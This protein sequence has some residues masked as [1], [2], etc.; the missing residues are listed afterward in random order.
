LI[1]L[2]GFFALAWSFSLLASSWKIHDC[3]HRG[4]Y[5]PAWP[6]GGAG[7]FGL[8]L[9]YQVGARVMPYFP[10]RHRR[11]HDQVAVILLKWSIFGLWFTRPLPVVWREFVVGENAG[12]RTRS[13]PLRE[14]FRRWRGFCDP[15]Q[16]FSNTPF[17]LLSISCFVAMAQYRQHRG[18]GSISAMLKKNHVAVAAGAGAGVRY[19]RPS[20]RPRYLIPASLRWP[21]IALYWRRIGRIWAGLAWW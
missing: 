11:R 19:C 4:R 2:F 10:G 15:D 18:T 6:D 21:L 12:R 20:A 9:C 3:R 17:L 16:L 1:R 8:A 13:K 5:R 14:R 7:R